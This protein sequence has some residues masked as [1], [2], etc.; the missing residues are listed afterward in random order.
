M[1]KISILGTILTVLVFSIGPVLKTGQIHSYN[2]D[3]K[4]V[5]YGSIR[6]DG[7]YRAGKKRSYSRD[8]NTVIDNT[9]GLQWEDNSY[10][11]LRWL[12]WKNWDAGNYDDTSGNTATAYCSDLTL[13]GKGWRI[14]SIEEL[15]S[16]LDEG[17]YDPAVTDSVFNVID[18]DVPYWS[19]TSLLT[20][21]SQAWYAYF[22][23]ANSF[24]DDKNKMFFVRC[25]RGRGLIYSSFERNDTSQTVTDATTLLQWQDDKT[26]NTMEKTWLEAI[27]YCENLSLGRHSDW[28]L[29]NKNELLS[30]LNRSHQNPA[31]DTNTFK[32]ISLRYYWSSTSS[33]NITSNAWV[34]NFSDGDSMEADKD[35][36]RHIVRCARGGQLN[37]SNIFNPSII[38]YLFN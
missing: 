2:V 22:K 31:I 33:T 15:E 10:T 16:I 34:V 36:G 19:S 24:F 11:L 26:A 29:P 1:I 6:D 13:N 25:V 37:I 35:S 12:T 17:R 20:N 7:Y 8:G 18:P 28:R 21:A 27:E 9:T 23:N 3:G 30:I 32:K 14:P 4:V 5:A 38:L